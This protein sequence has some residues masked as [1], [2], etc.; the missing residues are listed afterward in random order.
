[1]DRGG[2][3]VVR[4]GRL[5]TDAKVEVKR[6]G[7]VGVVTELSVMRHLMGSPVVNVVSE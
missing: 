7:G 1:V 4:I 2:D 6:G 3:G 5:T